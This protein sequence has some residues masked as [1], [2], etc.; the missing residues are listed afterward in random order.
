MFTSGEVEDLISDATQA[1]AELST[2]LG[3]EQLW[4][5]KHFLS[6][7]HGCEVRALA[8]D[9]FAWRPATAAGFVA[10]K[11]IELAMNWRG[12][13]IP[14]TLVDEA[15]ARLADQPTDRG[16]WVAGLTEAD[17]ADLRGRAV[18][19]VTRFLQ[20]FPPLD[21]RA[22]PM[23]EA[24]IKWRPDGCVE[25]AGKADLVMGKPQGRESRRLIVDFKTGRR[26][27][28]HREDLRFYALLETLV[29]S[30]PPRRV[31][32]YYLDYSECDAEDVTMPLL[33]SSLRRM[34]DGIAAHIALT[35][36]HRAPRKRVGAP[37]TWCAVLGSCAE[38]TAHLNVVR[39]DGDGG[40]IA[41]TL[42]A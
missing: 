40:G 7:V 4:V 25:L 17:R 33:H 36:E 22:H 30:V 12:E 16:D 23:L 19:R 6:T 20:D 27:P 9:P 2:Q 31:A 39:G 11:A 42:L 1:L 34:L 21:P 26:S 28:V 37:C 18:E 35:I 32:T 8:P 41:D 15:I 29:T 38:G 24:S 5:N 13:P 10:H 14:A 3:G